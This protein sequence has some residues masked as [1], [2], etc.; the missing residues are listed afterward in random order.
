MAKASG[1][2]DQLR[3]VVYLRELRKTAKAQRDQR[4]A[5]RAFGGVGDRVQTGEKSDRL[6]RQKAYQERLEKDL[7]MR[8][9]SQKEK[10]VISSMVRA[11]AAKKALSLSGPE[12][13]AA[14]VKADQKR[15]KAAEDKEEK[16]RQMASRVKRAIRTGLGHKAQQLRDFE[17]VYRSTWEYVDELR[18]KHEVPST[19]AGPPSY[20]EL[21]RPES[22]Q[23]HRRGQKPYGWVQPEDDGEM[24]TATSSSGSEE[25]DK[26]SNKEG[27][28][29]PVGEAT[30][31]GGDKEP[32]KD[33][34]ETPEGG[35]A[36]AKEGKSKSRK[37][38]HQRLKEMRDRARERR[39]RKATAAQVRAS[40]TQLL[41]EAVS[42]QEKKKRKKQ[43]GWGQKDNCVCGPECQLPARW[44]ER[45]ME[46][47]LQLRPYAGNVGDCIADVMALQECK[48]CHKVL[49]KPCLLGDECTD[50]MKLC[51]EVRCH[52]SE[53]E[54]LYEIRLLRMT[55]IVRS[56]MTLERLLEH[57]DLKDLEAYLAGA[58]Q[59]GIVIDTGSM[60][61]PVLDSVELEETYGHL[62]KAFRDIEADHPVNPCGFCERQLP[63]RRMELVK[64]TSLDDR[65]EKKMQKA[66]KEKLQAR[67]EEFVELEEKGRSWEEMFPLGI[68]KQ[69]YAAMQT[70]A[71]A[72]P[73]VINAMGVDEVPKELAD[74]NQYEKMLVSLAKAF[75]SCIRL[76]PLG[77]KVPI[78]FQLKA[79]RG[80]MAQ[81]RIPLEE[82]VNHVMK[83]VEPVA[84]NPGE[85]M[86]IYADVRTRAKTVW[87]NLVRVDKVVAGLRW[88]K[89]NNRLYSEL[90]IDEEQMRNKLNVE[91][92]IKIV[93]ER[94]KS[95]ESSGADEDSAGEV[96]AVGDVGEAGEAQ[97]EGAEQEAEETAAQAAEPI[98][99][100][101]LDHR[102]D[103]EFSMAPINAG[104]V[105]VGK[106][107]AAYKDAEKYRQKD[108]KGDPLRAQ[109]E[110]E[111][112][113]MCF[114]TL[115]PRAR[116]G[117]NVKVGKEPGERRRK[118]RPSEYYKYRLQN[119]DPRFRRDF[120]YLHVAHFFKLER[121]VEAGV[122]ASLHLG[123]ASAKLSKGDFVKK[124][125]EGSEELAADLSVAFAAQKGTA[126]YWNK[127]RANLN[128]MDEELGPATWF[129]TLSC[130]EQEWMELRKY[131]LAANSDWKN[132]SKMSTHE[133]CAKDP[134]TVSEF[135]H[136][137]MQGFLDEVLIGH[138]DGPLGMIDHY[139]WR[140]E[141][142]ARG[143]PHV[144][145][146]LW[147]RDA[148]VLGAEGVTEEQVLAHIQKYVTCS[149]P[150]LEENKELH[151]KVKKFQVHRCTPSCRRRR[152][153]RG[154]G[155]GK[156]GSEEQGKEK[157]AAK[158]GKDSGK[159]AKKE[160]WYCRYGFPRAVQDHPVLNGLEKTVKESA[161]GRGVA[162]LYGLRRTELE[163]YV[164][165]YNPAILLAWNANVDVQF[166][167]ESKLIL[168]KYITGY[169]TKGEHQQ[170]KSI[171]DALKGDQSKGSKVK[172]LLYA[173]NR[174][175]EVGTYEIADDL[176]GNALHG[177]SEQVIWLG[178]G[179]PGERSRALK[180]W[181][182]A[183]AEGETGEMF[184]DNL[185]ETYYPNR[186]EDLEDLSLYEVA[187]NWRPEKVKDE[188]K[189]RKEVKAWES[190]LKSLPDDAARA[191]AKKEKA[192]STKD[193]KLS[194][195]FKVY[196]KRRGKTVL[197][198][199]KY[200]P[201]SSQQAER[202]FQMLLM[203]HVP[204]RKEDQLLRGKKTY[205]EAF[206]E[207]VQLVPVL[208]DRLAHKERLR[209]AEEL[210]L[211]LEAE[212]AQEAE[213]EDAEEREEGVWP[214]EAPDVQDSDGFRGISDYK[215]PEGLAKRVATLNQKQREVYEKIMKVV[216]H[217]VGHEEL[218][219]PCKKPKDQVLEFVSGGAGTGKSRLIEVLS[220]GVEMISGRKVLITAPTG[221]AAQNVSGMTIH[222]AFKFP[223]QK[224]G[225][226]EYSELS[227][228]ED[229]MMAQEMYKTKLIIIDEISMVSNVALMFIHLRLMGMMGLKDASK[230][231]GFN[232]LVLGD[233]M[234]LPPVDRTKMGPVFKAI[235]R[236]HWRAAFKGALVDPFPKGLWREFSYTELTENMRQ[237]GDGRYAEI[238]NEMRVGK[239]EG[240]LKELQERIYKSPTGLGGVDATVELL[241]TLKAK[242]KT[243]VC[244]VPKRAQMKELNLAMLI[245][246]KVPVKFISSVD[247]KMT[248]DSRRGKPKGGGCQDADM[249]KGVKG[250][251]RFL[252]KNGEKDKRKTGNLSAELA[253]GVGARV[254]L[255]VNVDLENGLFNGAMG[256]VTA[257]VMGRDPN[258]RVARVAVQFDDGPPEP[259]LVERTTGSFEP[260]KGVS[261]TRCQFP[262]ELAYSITVHKSQGL[263]LDC[264]VADL[265]P[266]I[267]E[268]G[269]AYVALSRARSLEGLHLLDFDPDGVEY[270]VHCL[271][272]YCRLRKAFTDLGP[273]EGG[274]VKTR[275]PKQMRKS[276]DD[277]MGGISP[278]KSPAKKK[279]KPGPPISEDEEMEEAAVL[280]VLAEAEEQPQE[281]EAPPQQS[282][283]DIFDIMLEQNERDRAAKIAARKAAR[284]QR[285]A[286]RM[287]VEPAAVVPEERPA[288]DDLAFLKLSNTRRDNGE[289]ENICFVNATV[290]VVLRAA[291]VREWVLAEQEA[292]VPQVAKD[293]K[294][295]LG[296]L[297]TAVWAEDGRV[298]NTRAIRDAVAV[299]SRFRHGEDYSDMMQHCAIE[300]AEHLVDMS[301]A[302]LKK[303]LKFTKKAVAKCTKRG[304]RAEPVERPE[305][306][307]L[308]WKLYLG[309]GRG[310]VT[311][312]QLV[313]SDLHGEDKVRCAVCCDQAEEIPDRTGQMV[314]N[315]GVKHKVTWSV[316]KGQ[317]Q[318][319]LLIQV[320]PFFYDRRKGQQVKSKKKLTG[321]DPDLVEL[322]G[323]KWRVVAGLEHQ[324]ESV[325]AGHY[326]AY[327]RRGS[328]WICMSDTHCK[329]VQSLPVEKLYGILMELQE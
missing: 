112:D 183:E 195:D 47:L 321:L 158:D 276:L 136:R 147:Q 141:Y 173:A 254:M 216:K 32:A 118:I 87:R 314:P 108:I 214:C 236:R 245:E 311:L 202:F 185:I 120:E 232:L 12:R 96:V 213:Q 93:E 189:V 187:R 13:K 165:D 290:Q 326:V 167:G 208:K 55:V 49:A 89:E 205:S 223:V 230:F 162:K 278:T 113:L 259:H 234:Q 27:D 107:V 272:E 20:E 298:E 138:A 316:E 240:G 52:S 271:D 28:G 125:K 282:G 95:Q 273:L 197:I 246:E 33:A 143:A 41:E 142:Q 175:R 228:E 231:A 203:L 68:C 325:A 224:D 320:N 302:A 149:I 305:Q 103:S 301:G 4:K 31:S 88:L 304:C 91:E 106:D 57:G 192:D 119:R 11:E 39:K 3:R 29:A 92:F 6:E 227:H 65:S 300:F 134:V 281:E 73:M 85:F 226:F 60:T 309:Q 277:A 43:M 207:W 124:V 292:G 44:A 14:Q 97:R 48:G 265:G 297:L 81:L 327:G 263:S 243:P 148:P 153:Q 53:V 196:L 17:S 329:E 38:Y 104:K 71:V 307:E 291:A 268:T 117:M 267:F 15:S 289:C 70:G 257:V 130:A 284:L 255:T 135:F 252:E 249:S 180:K 164:N 80:N 114:P 110:A 242:G 126:E 178:V 229:K 155:K 37:D 19:S 206:D 94:E 127:Q 310:A 40:Q 220:E 222:K 170:T 34:A 201:A 111:L 67:M 145:M 69:C 72:G 166:V 198:R 59:A 159:G 8:T 280:A 225:K 258:G 238:L 123:K 293:V 50:V 36:Q 16:V 306:E 323:Q 256:T 152:G 26:E 66:T 77:R 30:E 56:I 188:D 133:L 7:L 18:V 163:R 260:V 98:L 264:V 315:E 318:R 279:R 317:E 5:L 64:L 102:L 269:Q 45:M 312:A 179:M 182:Q 237:K 82:T 248:R 286:E 215:T 79:T 101:D 218:K 10:K 212:G 62:W 42:S 146:K 328:K 46:K 287:E 247:T 285:D 131:L 217:Q 200:V 90:T 140:L 21:L 9:A 128:T 132:V 241:R 160:S 168:N 139:Y 161:K 24:V 308:V 319:L 174:T 239:V 219:I 295:A 2:M 99:T 100:Q 157:E 190:Y 270:D 144:H 211:K 322:A 303:L 58:K 261:V 193:K 244:L 181:N 1:R 76:K 171:W 74:L 324:G 105:A 221:L 299:Y 61:G 51:L 116:G 121:Q 172:R 177:G 288:D 209:K 274:P 122:Y 313:S 115:F 262:L 150:S 235:S 75:Y 84:N 186:H 233:L 184:Q 156:K 137:R 275:K 191:K 199:T 294:K 86:V 129:V 151:D 194:K 78:P 22:A 266:D 253:L 283:R 63:R 54:S 83:T 23:V 296:E 176:L 210:K 25:S 251:V 154:K 109:K 204:Y 35:E 250:L 169:I